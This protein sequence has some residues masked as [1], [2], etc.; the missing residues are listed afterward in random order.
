MMNEPLLS[1][2]I[3]YYPVMMKILSAEKNRGGWI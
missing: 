1:Q 2:I 3:I